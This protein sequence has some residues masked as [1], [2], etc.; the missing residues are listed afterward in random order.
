MIKELFTRKSDELYYRQQGIERFIDAQKADYKLALAEIER[1]RKQSHWIWYI[2]PQLVGLGRSCY[3]TLY[4]IRG[5]EEA[6]EYLQN[7]VLGVGCA[8]LRMRC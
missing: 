7:E 4:G 5:L 2:F 3:S 1:G 6:E 8:R